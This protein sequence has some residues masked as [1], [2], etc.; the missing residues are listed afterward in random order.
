MLHQHTTNP[1]SSLLRA[2]GNIFTQQVMTSS[3]RS[4]WHQVW[5]VNCYLWISIT[6]KSYFSL[7]WVIDKNYLILYY[8]YSVDQGKHPLTVSS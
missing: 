5:C 6:L 4:F 1:E 8:V 2:D 7:Q 3:E